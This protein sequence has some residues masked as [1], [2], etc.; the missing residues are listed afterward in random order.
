MRRTLSLALALA[1]LSFGE[2]LARAVSPRFEITSPVDYQIFQRATRDKGKIIIAGSVV[3]STPDTPDAIEASIIIQAYQGET[4]IQWQALTFDSHGSTFHG[5]I[6]APAG[7][8]YRIRVRALRKGTI[9]TDTNIEHVGLGEIFVIAGQSNSA[10]YGEQKNKTETGLISAFDGKIWRLTQDPEPGAGGNGGSFMPL[11]G[12]AMATRYHVPIGIVPMGIGS[13]SVREWLPQGTRIARL[14]TRTNNIVTIAP[15]QWE[16]AG[17][18]FQNFSHRLQ[19]LGPHGFRAVL[20][21]QGESD[22]NQSDPE[23]T[24]PGDLYRDYL[25]LLIQSSRRE[26]GWQIPWF[27]AQATYHNP[28]DTSSPDIRAAQKSLWASSIAL[29]GP[30]T[31]TLTGD[32]REKNG[33]GVHFSAKGLCEHARLW[34]EKVSP[35][36]DHQ[37]GQ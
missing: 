32:L 24:L 3:S 15:G 4:A 37:L 11:F 22:A 33:Q 14:P 20:W 8:W 30:D 23:R 2:N 9:I 5:E 29:E 31:D 1:S 25:T 13:T 21:H 16:V 36:L 19:H 26:A 18:I 6:S 34:T 27:V 35:W 7:G 12:D 28:G 10:N 17:K